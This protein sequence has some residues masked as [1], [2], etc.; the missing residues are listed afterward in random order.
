[1]SNFSET[2]ENFVIFRDVQ[3]IASNT[4]GVSAGLNAQQIPQ[5]VTLQ[6]G[7]ALRWDGRSPAS[8]LHD[9]IRPVRL[10]AKRV[11]D[12]AFASAAVVFLAPLLSAVAVAVKLTSPGP[13]LFVQ[14]REG[15]NGR[16]FR[17]LKFRSMR[18]N[19]CDAS[20]IAQTAKNDV[21]VTSLGRFLRKSSIDELPQ[22]FNVLRGDMSLVGPRPHVAGMQAGGVSYR[23]L[24]PYYDARLAMRPGITG[25]AQANGLRGSTTDAGVAIA[26]VDHD[27]AYIQNFTIWLDLKIMVMTVVHE[28]LGGSGE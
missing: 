1:M 15:L 18:S 26:R 10:A 17:A 22:L 13:V 16:K 9:R 8:V 12:L 24:V 28:F 7:L 19:N 11:F 6:S 2:Q 3:E 21:R 23:E 14:D 27:I 25:W 20:G 5:R 4:D